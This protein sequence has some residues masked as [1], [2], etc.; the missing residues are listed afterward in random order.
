MVVESSDE[1]D[2]N[3]RIRQI[4]ELDENPDLAYEDG[5]QSQI[6]QL[7]DDDEPPT[8]KPVVKHHEQGGKT[9]S[10]QGNL[11]REV[12]LRNHTQQ[13]RGAAF[14]PRGE[15]LAPLATRDDREDGDLVLDMSERSTVA[16]AT[17][18][19]EV[20]L[21]P[22]FS[23]TM[24]SVMIASKEAVGPEASYEAI[25]IHKEVSE[26]VAPI[27]LSIPMRLLPA[28]EKAFDLIHEKIEGGGK[29]PKPEELLKRGEEMGWKFDLEPFHSSQHPKVDIK[30][31]GAFSLLGE[32]IRWQ[33][34]TF[35]VL[36][37][38]RHAKHGEKKGKKAFSIGVPWK[39]FGVLRLGIKTFAAINRSKF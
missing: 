6:V 26:K 33:K 30:L 35:Q 19:V 24:G 29:M 25:T 3:E 21:D 14:P 12:R 23:L 34:G 5:G 15:K 8:R 36:S 28:L 18:D 22:T 20:R 38:V 10:I 9:R 31:D 16:K 1:E 39:L 32:N 7:L 37:F 17:K 11:S 27:N 13:H 2:F 4:E